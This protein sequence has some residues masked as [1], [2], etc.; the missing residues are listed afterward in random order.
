MPTEGKT[1]EAWYLQLKVSSGGIRD[2]GL[3]VRV[4]DLSDKGLGFRISGLRVEC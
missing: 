2:G 3:G 1:T 4:L